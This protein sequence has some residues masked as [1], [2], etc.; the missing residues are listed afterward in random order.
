MKAKSLFA[1]LA[2]L[3]VSLH[4]AAQEPDFDQDEGSVYYE[5]K[6]A[7]KTVVSI[8]EFEGKAFSIEIY[9]PAV[10]TAG[11]FGVKSRPAALF[12]AGAT[13]LQD[14][15]GAQG[16]LLD[17]MLWVGHDYTQ[18]GL[19]K[20]EQSY[21]GEQVNFSA[22]DFKDAGAVCIRLNQYIAEFR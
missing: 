3:M 11:G 1:I 2:C 22:A 20:S 19:K 10:K 6:M 9:S 5:G 21:F 15:G 12:A 18:S 16:I 8:L 7:G 13:V 14:N 4:A 17:G